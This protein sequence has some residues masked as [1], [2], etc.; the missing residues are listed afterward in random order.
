M[1]PIV[2]IRFAHYAVAMLLFGASAFETALAPHG[3][4]PVLPRSRA[5]ARPLALLALLTAVLW[6][7]GEVADIGRG[8]SDALNFGLIGSVLTAT[9]FG[10]AWLIHLGLALL[11]VVASV[12]DRPAMA[13]ARLV[14]TALLL[15]SL[16][17]VGHA[18]MDDGALGL[19]HR[20]NDMLHLLA[21]GFWLGALPPL[22]YDLA[23]LR[24]P[25]SA[26][27]ARE[28]LARFSGLG[29]IAVAVVLLT[30]IANA[31]LILHHIPEDPSSPYQLLLLAKIALVLAM[32][33]IAV[34]NRY[35]ATPRLMER[36]G[37]ATRALVIGTLAEIALGLVVVALVSVFGTL[38]P[39]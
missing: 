3:L 7:M 36:P 29:H 30:G 8:W 10:A 24:R 21:A 16:A 26:E 33:A 35:W 1:D 37:S 6:L 9:P 19:V 11:L 18:A 23:L 4:R 15:V 38:D 2:A 32:A 14:L 25:H 22:L 31:M 27:A 17:L 39:V 28:A 13:T 34:A 5:W 20:G 12:S